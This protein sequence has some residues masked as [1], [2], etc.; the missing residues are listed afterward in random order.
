MNGPILQSKIS[1]DGALATVSFQGDVSATQIESLIADLAV[2]RANMLPAVSNNYNNPDAMENRN[3]SVQDDAA[4]FVARL[5]N[6]KFRFWLRNIGIGWLA[7]N[8]SPVL[9]RGIGE[10][11]LKQTAG[12]TSVDDPGDDAP[13]H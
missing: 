7:F 12:L 6:G 9:A 8:V 11:L 5:S 13:R 4:I 2:I 1:E 10:Y 3:A